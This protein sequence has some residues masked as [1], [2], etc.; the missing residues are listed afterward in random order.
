MLQWMASATSAS[1][2][3]PWGP[4]GQRG[5]G[6]ESVGETFF[7]SGVS[8]SSS[9]ISSPPPRRLR[10][11]KTPGPVACVSFASWDAGEGLRRS[12]GGD[13]EVSRRNQRREDLVFFSGS[14]IACGSM[15]AFFIELLTAKMG[16][17]MFAWGVSCASAFGGEVRT[18]WRGQHRPPVAG[19]CTKLRAVAPP[20]NL[21][22]WARTRG[23]F[24]RSVLERKGAF[25][26]TGRRH[27]HE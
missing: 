12:G 25:E 16:G 26:R 27:R 2:T 1:S 11:A 3:A 24:D 15:A 20:C 18:A 4:W 17:R 7:S 13:P 21:S 14:G 10:G 5:R 8:S 22:R 6:A 9:T 19:G 23:F